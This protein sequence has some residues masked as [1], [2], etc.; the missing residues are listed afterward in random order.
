M[1]AYGCLP[2]CSPVIFPKSIFRGALPMELVSFIKDPLGQRLW[3][4]WET[5]AFVNYRPNTL[6][7]W[8][9]ENKIDLS[10]IWIG[11]SVRYNPEKVRNHILAS[12]LRHG[13]VENNDR[14]IREPLWDTEQAAAYLGYDPGSLPPWRRTKRHDLRPIQFGRGIRY[15]PI[16]IKTYAG[17]TFMSPE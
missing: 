3:N 17:R 11:R 4:T 1:T 13:P 6:V 15:C 9:L 16:F 14:Y 5:A 2:Y 7:I 12:F 8:R 10:P